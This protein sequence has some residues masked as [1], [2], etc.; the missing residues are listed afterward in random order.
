MRLPRNAAS[1]QTVVRQMVAANTT[2]KLIE[3]WNE[4]GE[5]TAVEPGEQVRYNPATQREELDPNGVPFNTLYVRILRQN[6]PAL[7]QGTGS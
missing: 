1:F 7:E 2:W 5:G 4:W 3:T 6:L